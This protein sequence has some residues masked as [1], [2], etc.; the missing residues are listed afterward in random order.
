MRTAAHLLVAILLVVSQ[1]A[2]AQ[3]PAASS[4]PPAAKDDLASFVEF[5]RELLAPYHLIPIII[6]RGERVGDNFD[7][8]TSTLIASADDCFPKLAVRKQPGQ[9]PSITTYSERGL[10]AALG[11]AGVLDVSGDGNV[12]RL[13]TLSFRDVEVQ[14]ASV[15][16]LRNAMDV[17]AAQECEA[18]RPFLQAL[19]T[20][21]PTRPASNVSV[22]G[23]KFPNQRLATL[24]TDTK[25]PK[26]PLVIGTVY[27]ARRVLRV[28]HSEN[29][30]AAGKLSLGQSFLQ[31]L[32]LNST[33]KLSADASSMTSKSLEFVGDAII[34]VA[35][36]AA[37]KVTGS[38]VA[39]GGKTTLQL[40][41]ISPE[42]TRINIALT[43]ILLKNNLVAA[44]IRTFD[45]INVG[46]TFSAEGAYVLGNPSGLS[47]EPH[48]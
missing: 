1:T 46:A 45:P 28:A 13:Y 42:E 7:S 14:T 11:A 9:L 18:I 44:T 12:K 6:P 41:E 43:E 5:E 47:Y 38:N 22:P 48:T 34:P 10:A 30:D 33:F 23:L 29:L 40:A 26:P 19:A 25:L 31:N 15:V 37:Y 20:S 21:K 4:T 32:G 36:Q 35:Y 16:Q 3:Q 2:N 39:E 24:A 27:Y 17:K 8:E